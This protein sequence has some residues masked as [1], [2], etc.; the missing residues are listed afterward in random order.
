MVNYF[1]ITCYTVGLLVWATFFALS[2][3]PSVKRRWLWE[4]IW[5]LSIVAIFSIPFTVIALIGGP[6]VALSWLRDRVRV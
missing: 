3:H 5:T 1:L 6:V 4:A 2:Y